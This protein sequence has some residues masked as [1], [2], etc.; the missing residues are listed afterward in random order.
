MQNTDRIATAV[1]GGFL[2][3]VFDFLYGDSPTVIT[4]MAAL[5]FL[6]ILDWLSGW[7]AAR[8]DG[9]YASHYGI[10]G[11]IR[12]FFMLLLPAGGHQL[13]AY[14]GL[15]GIIFGALTFGLIFHTLKSMTANAVRAGWADWLPIGIL[16]KVTEWVQ[17]EIESKIDRALKRVQER[18]M[19]NDKGN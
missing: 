1:A 17:S 3:P 14:V 10:N 11:V 15:P 6:I 13:D 9:S 16:D 5:T 8:K 12:T 4:G 19:N 7:S 18:T 2:V